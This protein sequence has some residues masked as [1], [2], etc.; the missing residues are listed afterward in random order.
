MSIFCVVDKRAAIVR[1]VDNLTS[2]DD[3]RIAYRLQESPANHYIH[4]DVGDAGGIVRGISGKT[5][6]AVFS[7]GQPHRLGIFVAAS[8]VLCVAESV[9][10][11]WS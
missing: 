4:S 8:N 10:R 9:S 11:G 2:A 7:A 1:T 3:S 6:T 5:N